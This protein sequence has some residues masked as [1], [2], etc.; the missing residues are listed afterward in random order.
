MIDRKLHYLLEPVKDIDI[1]NDIKNRYSSKEN[2]EP[3]INYLKYQKDN[4]ESKYLKDY[5]FDN[6]DSKELYLLLEKLKYYSYE[7]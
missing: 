1:I 4:K 2:N 3:I 7:L 6:R 5:N